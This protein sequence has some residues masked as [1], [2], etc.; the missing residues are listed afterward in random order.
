M[1][2]ATLY[3]AAL[4]LGALL[5]LGGA[6]AAQTPPGSL[7]FDVRNGDQRGKLMLNEADLAFESLTDSRH[8]RAWRYAEIRELSRKG[9]KEMRVRPQK[10]S[11]Y[12]F[13]FKDRKER[14]QI[15]EL[16]A[17]RVVTGRQTK[18]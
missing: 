3:S 1:K 16:I 11:R 5:S 2:R 4:L 9:R 17:S 6:A 13:Q 10:G 15:Y 7:V 18:K 8:S 12:D 14:D